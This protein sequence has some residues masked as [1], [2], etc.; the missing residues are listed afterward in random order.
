MT[1]SAKPTPMVRQWFEQRVGPGPA[2]VDATGRIMAQGACPV[3][4]RAHARE[5]GKV[6]VQA[7]CR[8]RPA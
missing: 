8:A 2:P 1:H 4:V 5:G 6:H 3:P 7:H